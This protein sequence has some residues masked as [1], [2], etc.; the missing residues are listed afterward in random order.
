MWC[1]QFVK[2]LFVYSFK[3]HSLKLVTTR[4]FKHDL[5][6]SVKSFLI[7]CHFLCSSKTLLTIFII[8][9]ILYQVAMPADEWQ[10]RVLVG[11]GAGAECEVVSEERRSHVGV[12]WHGPDGSLEMSTLYLYYTCY[13]SFSPWK[14]Y[15]SVCMYAK[16]NIA[17]HSK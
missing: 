15:S 8:S 2:R 17:S 10:L 9:V 1:L 4:S 5:I 12:S 3:E 6:E 13:W 11:F 16:F 14:N 7:P